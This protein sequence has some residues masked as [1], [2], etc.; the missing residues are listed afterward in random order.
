MPFNVSFSL[1]MI[2]RFFLILNFFVFSSL[3]S[4]EVKKTTV[5]EVIEEVIEKVEFSKNPSFDFQAVHFIFQPVYQSLYAEHR[6][7]L[8]YNLEKLKNPFSAHQKKLQMNLGYKHPF[9]QSVPEPSGYGFKDIVIQLNYPLVWANSFFGWTF[10]LSSFSRRS[11]LLGAFHTGVD[12]LWKQNNI[13]FRMKGVIQG[14]WHQYKS[15][16]TFP[17]PWVSSRLEVYLKMKTKWM[18]IMPSIGVYTFYDYDRDIH[19]YQAAVLEFS[20]SFKKM[21]VFLAFVWHS[22]PRNIYVNLDQ[23]YNYPTGIRMGLSWRV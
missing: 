12:K 17:N 1:I 16:R 20:H 3:S 10:P 7:S 4:G 22:D 19:S 21:V 13:S 15:V 23:F 14:L 11:S 8:F 6:L 5:I 9:V 18:D 2:F